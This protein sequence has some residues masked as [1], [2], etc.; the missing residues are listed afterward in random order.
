MKKL[1]RFLLLAVLSASALFYNSCETTE[2][3]ILAN[4]NAL[5][6]DQA[7]ANLLLNGIQLSYVG[8]ITTFNNISEDLTRISYMFG[9]NYFENYNQG[10]L[11]GPWGSL[12]SSINPDLQNIEALNTPENDL[13]FHIGVGKVLQAHLMMQLVD[14]LGDIPWSEA[15][16]PDEF[17]A[18]NLDDDAAV[19]AAANAIL[20]EA[21]ALLGASPATQGALDL[22]YGGDTSKWVRFANTLKM[23]S[24]LTTGDT[25]T[26][27]SIVSGGNFI[28]SSADDFE[29]KYGTQTLQPD[30]RHPD[31]ITDYR[32]DGANIYQNYWIIDVMLRNDDPRRRYYF[33]RQNECTPGASCDPAGNGETLQCSLQL[34]PTHL[35]GTPFENLWCYME[36]G[37]WG[38]MHGNDEGTPPDNFTRT[39]S[40]VY[41]AAG[42]FDDD[43]FGSVGL[44]LGGG[45]AGIEPI[46]LASYVD[47]MRAEVALD[48]GD[49]AGAADFMEAG[50]TKSI[51]KV[52][53]FGSV[54]SSADLAGFEPSATDVTDYIADI[55]ADFTA[56]AGDDQWDIL[57]EQYF[58]TMFGGGGDAYNFYRR[59]GYPTTL[60][61]SI[62]PSPGVFPRTFLYPGNEVIANPNILQRTDNNTQVF[63]DTQ[64]AGPAFP[65]A[66]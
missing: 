28:S 63:W 52:Q 30:T 40:G 7:D 47:F 21:I 50:L 53:G 31:Y 41:P 59:T 27:S 48:A 62:D 9:R 10:S 38:R 18:P 43:S 22:F 2:L 24:A 29:F 64:P 36:D 65:S 35:V 54:D 46:M 44:G 25:G 26:F 8:G 51:A 58:V 32:S 57:A 15:N 14:F 61:P 20:D 33:Y 1:Y 34:T 19:Y 39:A 56:A 55:K 4:P 42:R 49:A 37:Y 5:S 45:G 23:R 13:S 17:D 12:Y 6:S 3:E 11:N 60:S 66:N 16:N